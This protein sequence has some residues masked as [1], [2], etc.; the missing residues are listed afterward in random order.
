MYVYHCIHI[1]IIKYYMYLIIF[2][3]EIG[4]FYKVN[5]FVARTIGTVIT[6]SNY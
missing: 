2:T 1:T 4:K 3:F 6:C 5:K